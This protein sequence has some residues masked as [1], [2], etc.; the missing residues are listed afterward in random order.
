MRKKIIWMCL[1]AF[2][3][4]GCTTV[5]IPSY[6]K[7]DHPYT[8]LVY[9]N[10]DEALETV[11]QVLNDKGWT[12]IDETDP[13]VYEHSAIKGEGGREI[14]LFTDIKEYPY[15]LGT[16][17]RRA[18]VFLRSTSQPNQTEMELRFVTI[19]SMTVAKTRKYKHSRA[20]AHIFEAV[21]NVLK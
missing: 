14:L 8:H 11:K 21:D 1:L 4:S 15:F 20:A 18:N 19:N 6:I 13:T 7:D 2:M 3:L 5:N 17:Y 16:R 10:F 9:A 12:V